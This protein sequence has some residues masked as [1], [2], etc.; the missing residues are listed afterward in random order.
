M[1]LVRNLYTQLVPKETRFWL[2]KIRHQKE[3]ESLKHKVF[4]SPK[5]DFSLRRYYTNKCVFVHITKAAGTSLALSLFGELP[6]HYTAQEYRVIYGRRDFNSFFK[7][8]FVRNPWD[9]LYSAY[10]YLKGGGWNEQDAQWSYDNLS[11]IQSFDDFVINWLS[12]DRLSSHIHLWPQS[13]F[14]CN[15]WGQPIIDHLGYFE[16][17]QQD[18]DLVAA[19]LNLQ[20]V[21][22]KHTNASKREGYTSVYSDA[23]IQKVA[24]LYSKDIANFGYQFNGLNKMRIQDGKFVRA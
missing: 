7:F 6:Y 11:D 1:Q 18:F 13:D 2:Y 5:G 10:S 4:P 22:L 14:I 3:M 8:T 24:A 21:N 12:E 19:R 20:Q 16:T 23:A 15:A 17:I 9:R